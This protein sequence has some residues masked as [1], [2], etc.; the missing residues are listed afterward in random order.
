MVLNKVPMAGF[1]ANKDF[2]WLLDQITEESKKLEK[3]VGGSVQYGVPW[4][5]V[6][7]DLV[8]QLNDEALL[9]GIE[10]FKQFAE[11]IAIGARTNLKA[12]QLRR[13]DAQEFADRQLGQRTLVWSRWATAA[14]I[15]A[16]AAT[17]A[18]LFR[19]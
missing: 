3:P 13:R 5:I 17:I 14:A 8:K 16:A 7:P 4:R 1:E 12:E 19:H 9:R 15:I 2:E 18:A 10:H 11:P 6:T